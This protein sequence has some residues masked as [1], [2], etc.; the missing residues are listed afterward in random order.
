MKKISFK[1]AGSFFIIILFIEAILFATLYTTIV[2]TRINEEI[3]ALQLRGNSHRDV[4]EKHFDKRT[5]DHVTLMETE[6][7]T[8]VII[9]DQNRRVLAQSASGDMTEHLH[10]EEKNIPRKGTAFSSHWNTSKYICTI[11]PI[12]RT[13]N[14]RLRLHVFGDLLDKSLGG[15]H[16]E[17]VFPKLRLN[18]RLNARSYSLVQ[19]R[20]SEADY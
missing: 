6:A 8:N 16:Y 9:T 7:R 5:I 11:S 4:L 1:L 13:G 20:F 18:R 19:P 17:A 10:F 2:N 15:K 14:G 12:E 3:R